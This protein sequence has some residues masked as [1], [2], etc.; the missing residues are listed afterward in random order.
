METSLQFSQIGDHKNRPEWPH[1]E[2]E[3]SE[4]VDHVLTEKLLSGQIGGIRIPRFVSRATCNSVVQR[5][6]SLGMR[7]YESMKNPL[8]QA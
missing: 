8:T 5:V 2:L 1:I 4:I 6:A 3:S 7:D